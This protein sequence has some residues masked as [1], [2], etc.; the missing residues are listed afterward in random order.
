MLKLEPVAVFCI[1]RP[2]GPFSVSVGLMGHQ[3]ISRPYGPV[4]VLVDLM[5]QSVYQ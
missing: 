3:C 4:S 2:Y 1:S 5:G